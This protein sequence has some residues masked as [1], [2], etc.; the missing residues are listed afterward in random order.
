MKILSRMATHGGFKEIL[1]DTGKDSRLQTYTSTNSL[2]IPSNYLTNID[3][4][5]TSPFSQEAHNIVQ[6]GMN[7]L[8]EEFSVY[9]EGKTLEIMEK[10]FETREEVF[11]LEKRMSI[12]NGKK[13]ILLEKNETL[14]DA[15]HKLVKINIIRSEENILL[16]EVPGIATAQ[17]VEKIRKEGRNVTKEI[18][19]VETFFQYLHGGTEA[20]KSGIEDQVIKNYLKI[21]YPD[22]VLSSNERDEIFKMCKVK[23]KELSNLI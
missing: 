3:Y 23:A 15:I 22:P 21:Q 7:L 5:L 19:I 9:K 12:T 2:A 10:I 1:I 13:V 14:E 4:L 6:E 20:I 11:N 18:A 16:Q 17:F 8:I